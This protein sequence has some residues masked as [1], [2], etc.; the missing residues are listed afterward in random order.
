MSGFP[1]VLLE[2]LP[3]TVYWR[4]GCV[5]C[6]HLRTGLE[7]AEVRTTFVNIWENPAAAAA[8]RLVAGGNETVPTVI[9]GTTVMVNPTVQRVLEEIDVEMMGVT[10]METRAR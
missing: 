1:I 3:V 6:E 2:D 7:R 10:S 9:V 4:P 5:Y 8:V